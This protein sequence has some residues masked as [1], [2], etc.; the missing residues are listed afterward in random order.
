M[1]PLLTP[2]ESRAVLIPEDIARE[3]SDDSVEELMETSPN[4]RREEDA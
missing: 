1:Q 2:R 3:A 4:V